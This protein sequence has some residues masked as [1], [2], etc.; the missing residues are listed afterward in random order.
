MV[1]RPTNKDDF[2]DSLHN[3]IMSHNKDIGVRAGMA[4]NEVDSI[5][6]AQKQANRVLCEHLYDFLVIEGYVERS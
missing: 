3:F 2:V 4:E 6:E 1:T 5:L